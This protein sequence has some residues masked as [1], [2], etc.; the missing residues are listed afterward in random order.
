M[1]A[2]REFETQQR[3]PDEPNKPLNG[4]PFDGRTRVDQR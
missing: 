3:S 2:F 1:V 4:Q